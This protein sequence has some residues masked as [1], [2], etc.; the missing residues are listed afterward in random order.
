MVSARAMGA[1][2]AAIALAACGPASRGA[3]T[4]PVAAS[5]APRRAPPPPA[6]TAGP[7]DAAQVCDRIATLRAGGCKELSADELSRDECIDNMRKSLEDRGPDAHDAATRVGR[8]FMGSDD[9]AVTTACV[10][11]ALAAMGVDENAPLRTCAQTDV[12]GAVGYPREQWERRKGA[13]AAHFSEVPSSKDAPIEVCGIA[14]EG[15]WLAQVRCDD[16]S[17]AFR[18]PAQAE[19]ARVG[20]VGP[21]GRCGAIVDLYEVRCPEKSYEVFI[22]AYVCPIP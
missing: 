14:S 20:N 10:D 2:I 12:Y 19:P 5:R 8:C 9:C 18:S 21:G 7:V 6:R 17:L 15:E 11:Q 16:G 3:T 1:A 22:D 13:R 4:S